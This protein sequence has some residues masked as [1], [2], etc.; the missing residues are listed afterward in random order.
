[1]RCQR[2]PTLQDVTW[3]HTYFGYLTGTLR[4]SRRVGRHPPKPQGVRFL[5]QRDDSYLRKSVGSL[6]VFNDTTGSWSY[7]PA[8][9]S[10]RRRKSSHSM[11]L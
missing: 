7:L 11:I 9:I 10:K 6:F 3:L 8:P 5:S 1:M 4:T 2:F